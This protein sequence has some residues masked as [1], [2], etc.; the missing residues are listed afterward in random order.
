[1]DKFI[2]IYI[3]LF[4]TSIYLV[5]HFNHKLKAKLPKAYVKNE[6]MFYPVNYNILAN[7]ENKYIDILMSEIILYE[8]LFQKYIDP[9]ISTIYYPKKILLKYINDFKK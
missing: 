1:M 8:V 7:Y 3:L 4:I 9:F 2:Y 5:H 6:S